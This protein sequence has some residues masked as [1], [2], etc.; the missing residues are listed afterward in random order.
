M[1]VGYVVYS[2]YG[3]IYLQT[4]YC[5]YECYAEDAC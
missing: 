5:E 3:L 2:A 1:V 4:E